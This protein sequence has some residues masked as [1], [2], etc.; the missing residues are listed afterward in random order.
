MLLSDLE[1]LLNDLYR[2]Q[3][4]KDHIPL[5]LLVEGKKQ[6]QKGV[7]AV[8]FSKNV[9]KKAIKSNADFIVVHHAHGFWNNQSRRVVG[10]QKEKLKLLLQHEI[11]LFGYHLPM[12]AQPQIGNNAGILQELGLQKIGGFLPEGPHFIGFTGEFANKMPY[13]DFIALVESRIGKVNFHFNFGQNFVKSVA[14]CSGGAAG[15]IAEAR[16]T[17]VDVF[18]SGEAKEDTF[19]FCQDENFNFV[20]AGHYNTE[21]FG[22]KLLAQYLGTQS[23]LPTQFLEDFNP[24]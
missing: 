18:L 5:G 3:E 24:V 12:D 23:G 21:V 19:V 22:P 10:A 16:F 6:V 7:T 11:S 13:S 8:S 20:A 2:P 17:D 1:K 9:L 4:F 15:S 14:V